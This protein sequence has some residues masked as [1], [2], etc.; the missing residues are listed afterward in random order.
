MNEGFE[1]EKAVMIEEH[2]DIPLNICVRL[3]HH[4]DIR[5]GSRMSLNPDAACMSS[6][7]SR[8]SF[9]EN[10]PAMQG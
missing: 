6:E 8:R 2:P 5:N 1:E 4:L 10:N 3:S 7:E 9:T